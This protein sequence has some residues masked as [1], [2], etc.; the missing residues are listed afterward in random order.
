MEQEAI[1]TCPVLPTTHC[2]HR[3]I[4]A[5]VADG[6]HVAGLLPSRSETELMELN[7]VQPCSMET[8]V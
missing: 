7:D 5:V 1:H 8:A 4:R 6:T 2:S 3:A